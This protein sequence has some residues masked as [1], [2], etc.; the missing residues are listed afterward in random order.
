MRIP[1]DAEG[2]AVKDGI[3]HTRY[4]DHAEGAQRTRT[5][6]GALTLGAKKA[7]TECYPP[8]TRKPR[9]RTS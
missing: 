1:T 5:E 3:L 7:C 9:G 2:Y 8:K 6:V 4:A